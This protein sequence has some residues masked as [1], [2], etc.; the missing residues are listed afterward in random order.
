MLVIIRKL[1]GEPRARTVRPFSLD[2]RNLVA[3][4]LAQPHW[5]AVW[6]SKPQLAQVAPSVVPKV[7]HGPVGAPRGLDLKRDLPLEELDSWCCFDGLDWC[8]LDDCLWSLND[9]F[10][11]WSLWC[12]WEQK[13]SNGNSLAAAFS[14]SSSE[15]CCFADAADI[16]LRL[17][18]CPRRWLAAKNA[19]LSTIAR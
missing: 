14:P 19:T 12:R 4:A 9:G 13:A 7:F 16:V 2:S 6:P 17:E 15:A 10:W 3:T 18:D 8:W 11:C 1:E 5:S